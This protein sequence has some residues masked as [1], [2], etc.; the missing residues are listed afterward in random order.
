MSTTSGSTLAAPRHVPPTDTR[1]EKIESSKADMQSTCQSTTW[2]AGSK[3]A[4]QEFVKTVKLSPAVPKDLAGM[5]QELQSAYK[6]Y[7]KVIEDVHTRIKDASSRASRWKLL[8]RLASLLPK[9]PS[10]CTLVFQTCEADLL[11]A[12]KILNVS[13]GG[14]LRRSLV[15]AERWDRQECLQ[16]DRGV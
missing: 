11:S 6:E 15:F 13:G 3:S 5:P 16:K 4:V 9:G 12:A 1:D 14:A 8:E 2:P 10:R 7:I